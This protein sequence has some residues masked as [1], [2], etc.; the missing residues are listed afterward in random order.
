MK[1]KSIISSIVIAGM[2]IV[3]TAS[4]LPIVQHGV[5]FHAVNPADQASLVYSVNGVANASSSNKDVVGTIVRDP[6]DAFGGLRVTVVGFNADDTAV[7]TSCTVSAVTPVE[8]GN[9][10]VSKSFSV[11]QN[12]TWT[13]TTIFNAAEAGP[14]ASFFIRC[15]L[16]GN[17]K[18]RIQSVR[19]PSLDEPGGAL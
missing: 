16:Q 9:T 15:T 18:S 6:Q 2:G 17:Q 10:T 19:I 1:R 7:T 8:L 4:A 3:S 12:H 11:T 5:D 14:K 13:R